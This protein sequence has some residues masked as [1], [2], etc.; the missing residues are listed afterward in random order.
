[1][2]SMLCLVLAFSGATLTA[3]PADRK[4]E[5]L[6][7]EY[8]AAHFSFL[9]HAGIDLGL[10]EYDGKLADYRRARLDEHE[11]KLKTYERQFEEIPESELSPPQR[12]DR[13]VLLCLLR[14]AIF[15]DEGSEA[16]FR[17]PIVYMRAIQLDK[18]LVRDFAPLADRVRS[19]IATERQIPQFLAA[20]RENLR[21]VLARPL[22]ETAIKMAQGAGD[23]LERDLPLAMAKLEDPALRS[24]L[25]SANKIAAAEVRAYAKWL[26][27]ERLPNVNLDFAYGTE[28]YARMLREQELVTISPAKILELGLAELKRE[29]EIFA[30][31]AKLLDPSRPA[32]KVFEAIQDDHPIAE[33]LIPD[34]ARN[35][36][37]IRKFVEER[38]LVTMPP[39]LN[40]TLAETPPFRRA[41]SFASMDAPGPFETRATAAYYYITPVE[42]SWT[43]LQQH[44]W[45]TAFNYYTT[46]VV[47]IHEAYPGHYLQHRHLNGSPLSKV[48]KSFASYAFVEGW[49][50]YTEQMVLDAG[51]P[52]GD[53]KLKTAR[54]RL[55]QS[56]EALLRLC[57]LCC[58]LKM[59]C[60]GMTPDEATKFFQE[61]CYYQEV[62]ARQEATRGTYDPKYLH[63]T[64]G[65]LMILKLRRDW[66]RQEGDS[67]SLQRFHDEMLSH[68]A[69]PVPLLR[70]IMLRDSKQWD[71]AL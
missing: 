49:A 39:N 14:N 33:R 57:R 22:V 24:E 23:F 54:Y 63:Y 18:Y 51:F 13:Q 2:G 12:I 71:E 58:S 41:V 4:F 15:L 19:I 37:A 53:D 30:A 44:E 35:L 28:A 48:R 46:D 66:Q 29:Q 20:A 55:A 65:K 70:R 27:T 3:T 52:A 21:P 40:V 68:G 9:P 38:K 69:P 59:H 11:V 60:E 8:L 26:Q 42:P 6:A 64:L 50:H 16:Y 56:D 62:P 43:P 5:E 45:L 47:S 17:N 32:I 67:F 31:T 36:E 25:E 7:D 10:H 61:N 34:T 1:M